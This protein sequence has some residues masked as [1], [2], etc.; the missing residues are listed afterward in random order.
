MKERHLARIIAFQSLYAWDLGNNPGLETVTEFEWT[1]D[2]LQDDVKTFA[3]F[4]V[5]GTIE[6][7]T[8]IDSIIN[9]HLHRW[10]LKRLAKVDLAVLRLS[11]YSLKYQKDVPE[12]VTI[13][14]AVEI[15]KEFGSEKSYKFI[16][17]ILDNIRKSS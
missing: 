2:P 17:G 10:E 16:N 8:E 12:A 13:N 6:N 5:T 11:V 4:L 7:I 3:R 9:E 15:A 14:E 1:K